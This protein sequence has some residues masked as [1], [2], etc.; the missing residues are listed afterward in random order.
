MSPGEAGAPVS[1]M[2]LRPIIVTPADRWWTGGMFDRE[3]STPMDAVDRWLDSFD[4]IH[5]LPDGSLPR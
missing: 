5:E 3:P 2:N 4:P 1:R